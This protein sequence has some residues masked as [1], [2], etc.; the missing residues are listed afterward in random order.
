MSDF[1]SMMDENEGH[2]LE[3]DAR[4]EAASS[5]TFSMVGTGTPGSW[6]DVESEAGEEE[7]HQR[8]AFQGSNV[9]HHT[10]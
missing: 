9:L 10:L 7:G 8:P 1:H 6:T 5:D 2:D 4:S 3:M